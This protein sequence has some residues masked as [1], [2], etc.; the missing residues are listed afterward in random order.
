M[1]FLG[2]LVKK[3]EATEKV[4]PSQRRVRFA[5]RNRPTQGFT[6]KFLS[7]L[8]AIFSLNLQVR[9]CTEGRDRYAVV[10]RSVFFLKVK[11][12]VLGLGE[13]VQHGERID[14]ANFL[15]NTNDLRGFLLRKIA[16]ALGKKLI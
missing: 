16:L 12:E 10:C 6:D 4:R 1:N 2:N 7:Q 3:R 11:A 8:E 15:R 13:L 14:L 5:D 9:G